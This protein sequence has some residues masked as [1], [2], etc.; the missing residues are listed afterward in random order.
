MTVETCVLL[1]N[2]N[3]KPDAV[4]RMS[5]DMDEYYRIVDEEDQGK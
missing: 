3:R 1:S 2:H 5:L 4:V